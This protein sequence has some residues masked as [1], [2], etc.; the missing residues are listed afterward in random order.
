MSESDKLAALAVEW[1]EWHIFLSREGRYWCARYR[2]LIPA[3]VLLRGWGHPDATVIADSA[4]ELAEA[5]A[6]QPRHITPYRY[7]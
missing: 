6:K 3:N 1:P 5:L 2:P 7:I 4:D